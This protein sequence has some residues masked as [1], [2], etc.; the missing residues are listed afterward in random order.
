MRKAVS[1]CL[2]S[3]KWLS[4]IG[5]VTVTTATVF[6][7]FLLPV[8]LRGQVNHPYIGILA[9]LILPATFIAG[10]I[11]IPAGIYLL[12]RRERLAPSL[13]A[14][15]PPLNWQNRDFR[16]LVLFI[17]VTTFLNIIVGSQLTYS[18]VNYMDTV[19]FCGMTCHTVMQPQYTAHQNSPY[20]RVTCVACHIG[21]GASWFVRSKLSGMSQVF[22]TVLADYPRPIPSPVQNLRPA[23]ETCEVCHWPQ[24]WSADR[25]RVIQQFAGDAQNTLT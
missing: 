15:F 8:T 7:L 3:N 13:R 11:L 18:A 1:A 21:P 23:R 4:L 20:A 2:L 25:L 14:S 16:R 10:L 19:T 5:M 24:R 12:R 22:H 9:F 6:W 17:G